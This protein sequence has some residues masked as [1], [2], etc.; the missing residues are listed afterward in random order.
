MIPDSHPI[1]FWIFRNRNE[2]NINGSDF[3][4]TFQILQNHKQLK[5]ENNSSSPKNTQ[6]S[7]TTTKTYSKHI[8]E[9]EFHK[10]K[11]GE[12]NLS[13]HTFRKSQP[14]LNKDDRLC[15]RQHLYSHDHNFLPTTFFFLH[16]YTLKNLYSKYFLIYLL[17]HGHQVCV[18][19][20]ISPSEPRLPWF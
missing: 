13:I 7:I 1:L 12:K 4:Y 14:L 20:V 5:E 11:K 16:F 15:T 19:F 18:L 2:N 8:S 9:R 3:R 17:T 6:A 10:L